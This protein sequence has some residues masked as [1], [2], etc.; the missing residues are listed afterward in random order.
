MIKTLTP[1]YLNIPWISPISDTIADSFVL[2]IYIWDGLI[3]EIPTTPSYSQT[4]INAT[5]SN[6]NVSINISNLLADFIDFKPA[7]SDTTELLNGNNQ[8]WVKWGVVHTVGGV[9][10]TIENSIKL[11]S[12]VNGY[13]YGLDGVNSQTPENKIL[14]PIQEYKVSRKSVFVIPIE[15]DL[16]DNTSD[17][18]V[19]NS[20]VLSSGTT[21]AYNVTL[22]DFDGNINLLYRQNGVTAWQNAGTYYDYSNGTYALDG[23]IPIT[24]LVDVSII[25]VQGSS[26]VTSNILTITI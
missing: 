25:F 10:E 2:N 24:G 17:V 16:G 22:G 26:I 4:K 13:S 15:T 5:E 19:L 12:F 3:D 14:I 1:Y 7:S 11:S 21:Y 20:V 8:Q 18:N 9:S 23:V 6:E